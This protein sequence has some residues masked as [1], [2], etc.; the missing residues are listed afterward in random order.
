MGHP[1]VGG[2]SPKD[3]AQ[4]RP[5]VVEPPQSL[6]AEMKLNPRTVRRQHSANDPQRNA[7]AAA[8]DL[9]RCG[10]PYCNGFGAW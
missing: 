4:S 5:P 8:T 10:V 1:S 9:L 3:K 6:F 2:W 7:F